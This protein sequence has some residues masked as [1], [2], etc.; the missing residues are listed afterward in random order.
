[1]DGHPA[2]WY[3]TG[4]A[5]SP[6]GDAK[7]TSPQAVGAGETTVNITAGT[8]RGGVTFSA[9]ALNVPIGGIYEVRALLYIYDVTGSYRGASVFVSGVR[10]VETNISG[11]WTIATAVR[12]LPIKS[13]DRVG[14]VTSGD[15]NVTLQVTNVGDNLSMA[16]VG[17]PLVDG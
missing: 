13:G 12:R 17:P 11:R 9:N 8:L 1:L 14:V 5:K 16:Y 10:V 4:G 15:A 3:P 7:F 6:Y 2:G